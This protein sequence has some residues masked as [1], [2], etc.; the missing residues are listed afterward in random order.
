MKTVFVFGNRLLEKDS[1]AHEVAERLR[2]K[3]KGIEFEE[4]ESL[5][6]IKNKEDLYIMDVCFGLQK[7]ETIRDISMLEVRQPVSAHDF[8]LA[9]ELKLREKLGQVGNVT[10]IAI[11]EG[12]SIGKAVSEAR[13]E[14][15]KI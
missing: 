15:E 11:P 14:L 12:Y 2:G 9:M 8:D 5:D 1:L 13:C 6:G 7:V 4:A 10:I 3:V